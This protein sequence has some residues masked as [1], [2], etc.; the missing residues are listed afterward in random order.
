[1]AEIKYNKNQ[2]KELKMN[3]Y[4]KDCTEK[5]IT[6]TDDFKMKVIKLD[7]K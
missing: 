7:A 3:K 2:I 5:Y 6:F 1:M 4:V